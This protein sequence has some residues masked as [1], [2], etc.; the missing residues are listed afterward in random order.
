MISQKQVSI[1]MAVAGHNEWNKIQKRH[2]VETARACGAGSMMTEIITEVLEQL[3]G[4]ID[5]VSEQLPESFPKKLSRSLF[6]GMQKTA[7][8]LE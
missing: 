1:A 5:R 6:E 4:V 3:P 8:R 2:W 7:L